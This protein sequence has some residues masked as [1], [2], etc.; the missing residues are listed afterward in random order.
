MKKTKL[1][2]VSV[3]SL[4]VAA[5]VLVCGGTLKRINPVSP[6]RVEFVLEGEGAEADAAAFIMGTLE[7]NAR[8]FM[9]TFDDL[10]TAIRRGGS[11]VA[12]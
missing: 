9:R 3:E 6:G 4:P 11:A 7:V 1:E 2:L 12:K 5:A 8:D 10:R